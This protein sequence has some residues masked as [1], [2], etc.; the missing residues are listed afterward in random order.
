MLTRV[1]AGQTRFVAP[2][3]QAD[4]RGVAAGS[5]M[6]ARFP[7][8]DR[9]VT[10]FRVLSANPVPDEL[11][12]GLRIVHARSRGGLREVL[13]FAP[14]VAAHVAADLAAAARVAQGQCFT[15]SGRHFVL[16]RDRQAPLGYD[17][18]GL[19]HDD[20]VTDATFYLPAE[21]VPCRF[22][23]TVTFRHLVLRLELR[24]DPAAD[25]TGLIAEGLPILLLARR[26]IGP[27]LIEYLWRSRTRAE[28][29][30]IDPGHA[31][32]QAVT[33]P[34]WL[35]RIRRMSARLGRVLPAIPGVVVL[36]SVLDN[37]AVAAGFS[38]PFHLGNCAGALRAAATAADG[39]GTGSLLLLAPRPFGIVDVS[40]SPIFVGLDDLVKLTPAPALAVPAAA[41]PGGSSPP[42]ALTVKLRL[43]PAPG[44]ASQAVAVWIPTARLPWL[45][46]LVYALPATALREYRAAMTDAGMLVMGRDRIE[47]I[48][49]GELLGRVGPGV[50][51]PLGSVPAPAVSPE[52]LA[53]RL[54]IGRGDIWVFLSAGTGGFRIPENSLGPLDRQ[55]LVT[56]LPAAGS[57]RVRARPDGQATSQRPP[58]E[59]VN[60]PLGAFPLWGLG[61]PGSEKP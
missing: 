60:D 30:Q 5:E 16:F 20:V 2:G 25:L 17:A 1:S 10:F 11:W 47:G 26:G 38:H 39:P 27:V 29:V 59:I 35:F 21:A 58:P 52:L 51:A 7:T 13:V 22:E 3:L 32:D 54:G 8:F 42:Q 12:A 46:R 49:F 40:P 19:V 6:V 15:G 56:A 55:L 41:S 34:L 33:P 4:A 43:V 18:A 57:P 37:V 36:R 50:L 61:R 14:Y 24:R 31:D 23:G 45:Q 53:D 48:P 28:A 44:Q 9:M